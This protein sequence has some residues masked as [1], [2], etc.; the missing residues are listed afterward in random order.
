[1]VDTFMPYGYVSGGFYECS[2]YSPNLKKNGCSSSKRMHL[3]TL[4]SNFAAQHLI[5]LQK[6]Q[7]PSPTTY[8]KK[9]KKMGAYPHFVMSPIWFKE[10]A[11]THG[12]GLRQRPEGARLLVYRDSLAEVQASI[13]RLVMAFQALPDLPALVTLQ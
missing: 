13:G 5:L 1:M 10:Q 11:V 7:T 9:R 4:P 2:M 6:S 3:N 8:P 12:A